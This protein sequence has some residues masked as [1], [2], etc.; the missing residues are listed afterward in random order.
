M[1][2]SENVVVAGDKLTWVDSPTEGVTRV[3]LEREEDESGHAIK[4][5]IEQS[6]SLELPGPIERVCHVVEL[7]SKD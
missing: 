3:K 1:D 6:D 7:V 5:V 2:F 4:G